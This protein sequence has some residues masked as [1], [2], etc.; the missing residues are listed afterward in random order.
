[1]LSTLK[2][3]L[4]EKDI[5]LTS[6]ELNWNQFGRVPNDSN[7]KPVLLCDDDFVKGEEY[8]PVITYI[9]GYV[10]FSINKRLKCI[11]CKRRMIC[12]AADV[13]YIEASFTDGISRGGLLLSSP[14]MVRIALVSYL[15][16]IKLCESDEF[17]KCSSQRDFAVKLSLSFLELEDFP[18]F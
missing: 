10:C 7:E 5:T 1:M 16:I 8:L 18:F 15:V 4:K 11:C 12:D 14:E 17:R 13:K 3:K 6:F 9:A 2:L